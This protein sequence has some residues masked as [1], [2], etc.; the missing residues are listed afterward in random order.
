V[1]NAGFLEQA[2]A[3]VHADSVAQVADCV[4]LWL[5]DR[6]ARAR[7]QEAAQRIAHPR[8]AETIARRVLAGVGSGALR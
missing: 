2:G 7:V 6:D 4:G 1:R 5:A 8:A 3:A